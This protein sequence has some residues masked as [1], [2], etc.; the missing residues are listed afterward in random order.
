MN[1]Y[2]FIAL[3]AIAPVF[4]IPKKPFKEAFPDS[5]FTAE[6]M[7]RYFEAYKQETK[8]LPKADELDSQMGR[9]YLADGPNNIQYQVMEVEGSKAFIQTSVLEPR[10]DSGPEETTLANEKKL[11][12][13]RLIDIAQKRGIF[14][15]SRDLNLDKQTCFHS[16]VDTPLDCRWLRCITKISLKQFEEIKNSCHRPD[17]SNSVSEEICKEYIRRYWKNGKLEK[18]RPYPY[19]EP[20]FK[21]KQEGKIFYIQYC[22]TNALHN[23]NAYKK[24]A[25]GIIPWGMLQERI[26][27]EDKLKYNQAGIAQLDECTKCEQKEDVITCTTIVTRKQF[28]QIKE[29]FLKEQAAQ[30]A[31]TPNIP[32][33]PD[34]YRFKPNGSGQTTLARAL[35]DGINEAARQENRTDKPRV[36]VDEI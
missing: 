14:F 25:S 26:A 16:Y 27:K 10:G 9:E 8:S 31:E 13:K 36:I 19:G 7:R 11:L 35:A 28:N 18:T 29:K 17:L 34:Q 22:F 1:R 21:F 33:H 23:E 12:S 4:G 32:I 2:Y 30:K 3:F 5:P 6:I 24:A 15:G 20:G